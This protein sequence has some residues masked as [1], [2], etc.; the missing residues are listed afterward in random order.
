MRF[1]ILPLAPE[2]KEM[3]N[4]RKLS[5]DIARWLDAEGGLI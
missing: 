4:N 2:S 1:Y 3:T 5:L